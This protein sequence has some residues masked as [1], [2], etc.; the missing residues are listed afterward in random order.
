MPVM[1]IC[2]QIFRENSYKDCLEVDM[3]VKMDFV[4]PP[5]NLRYVLGYLHRLKNYFH[6][7]KPQN[8]PQAQHI[9]SFS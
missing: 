2:Y 3:A 8:Y 5:H 9:S 6:P 4:H 1:M 7:D